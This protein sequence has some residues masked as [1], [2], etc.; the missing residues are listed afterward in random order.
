MLWAERGSVE[1]LELGCAELRAGFGIAF[2]CRNQVCFPIPLVPLV[3][4]LAVALCCVILVV[5]SGILP[6]ERKRKVRVCGKE[7]GSE[8]SWWGQ[9]GKGIQPNMGPG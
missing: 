9:A 8:P 1:T 7:G 5:T 2:F 4:W 6:L 3:G